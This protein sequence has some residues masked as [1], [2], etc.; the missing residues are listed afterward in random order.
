MRISSRAIIIGHEG[1]NFSAGAN[2][3]LFL[4]LSQNQQWDTLDFA[5]KRSKI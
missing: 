3:N 5:V 4:E 1:V 2:L